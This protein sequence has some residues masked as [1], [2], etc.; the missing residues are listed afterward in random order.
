M[1]AHGAAAVGRPGL[2]LLTPRA[3]VA[4]LTHTQATDRV[5]AP[6]AW[7]A[8]T[9]LAA[10]GSPVPAV[11]GC[12]RAPVSLHGPGRSQAPRPGPPRAPLWPPTLSPG[13]PTSLAAEAGPP[14]GTA[15]ATRRRVTVPIVGTGASHLAAGPEPACWAC[16]GPGA[17][18]GEAQPGRRGHRVGATYCG[19]GDPY[20]RSWQRLPV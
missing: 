5:A 17:G 9:A 7:A 6:V 12:N 11:T 18:E 14:G 15:A 13:L 8:V 2:T 16:C 3:C 19:S 4:G 20:S 10:V 1:R